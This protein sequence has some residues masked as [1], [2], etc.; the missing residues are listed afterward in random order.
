MNLTIVFHYVTGLLLAYA[1]DDLSYNKSTTQSH[2]YLGTNYVA[3]NA[4]DRNSTTCMRTLY[5]GRNSP[6]KTL[7]WKV[8]LGG[9]YNIYGVNVLFKS[10][11]GWN[12]RQRGRFAGFFLYVSTTG[13][14]Q[15]STLCYK[16][17]PLLP[18][19]NFT[20]ACSEYGR[21]VIFY[22]E[23]LNDLAYPDGYELTNVF[24]ELCE[25]IVQRCYGPGM[26]GSNCDILCPINCKYNTC[27]IQLGSC[28]GCN[29]GWART[30]CDTRMN[31]ESW[32]GDNCHHQC[33]G[34]CRYNSTCNHVTGQCERGCAAG[35]TGTLCD[36]VCDD[37]TY[38]HDCKNNCSGHCMNGSQCNKHTGY[39]DEGCNPGYIDSDCNRECELGYYGKNCSLACSPNCK[40]CRHTDGMCSCKA[41]WRGHNCTTEC[42][43]SYGE[44]CQYPCNE[45]CIDHKCDRF[46]GKCLCDGKH[47]SLPSFRKKDATECIF[48]IVAFSLSLATRIIF[49]STTFI[50]Q[51]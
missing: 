24:T 17:G 13:D 40:T 29:A 31:L 41:G 44:N 26:Y 9:V 49:I 23:R 46:N 14:I 16:D 36:R 7:W 33:I 50:L 12:H 10:Y 15:G 21:Y 43:R 42:F 6:D 32:Y 20:T 51:R 38:G 27:Q 47:D 25:V 11:E 30:T 2:T 8:D 5:I 18:P 45:H 39:C 48:W 35:W 3:D 19:L 1:Y 22:N 28:F 34:H 4:V 37:G